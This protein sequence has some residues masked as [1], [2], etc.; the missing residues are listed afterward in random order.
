M[1]ALHTSGPGRAAGPGAEA[2]GLVTGGTMEWPPLSAADLII[3][4]GV[5]EA[6]MVRRDGLRHADDPGQPAGAAPACGWFTGATALTMPLIEALDVLAAG[7]EP[8][9]PTNAGRT[10]RADAAGG[11]PRRR[12]PH[13]PARPAAGRRDHAACAEPETIATMD[14]GA[15]MLVAMPLWEVPG[16]RML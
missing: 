12:W 4:L 3:G 15:H 8:D 11:S 16:P 9:W 5:D 13:R 1:P 7:P 14:A 6:E 10:A 2:A